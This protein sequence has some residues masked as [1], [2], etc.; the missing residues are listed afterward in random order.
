MVE[1]H[2]TDSGVCWDGR[3]EG[4]GG[5]FC[6]YVWQNTVCDASAQSAI[7]NLHLFNS[8]SKYRLCV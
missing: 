4:C 1:F 2:Y 5:L 8:Y 7:P 3:E 6:E